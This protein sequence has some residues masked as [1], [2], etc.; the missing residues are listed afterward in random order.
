MSVDTSKLDKETKR[1]YWSEVISNFE[2]SGMR[3]KEYCNQNSLKYDHLAYYLQ[4]HR[5]MQGEGSDTDFIPIELDAVINSQYVVKVDNSIE[6]KLPSS[7]G[8]NQ[9]VAL[10]A[11]LRKS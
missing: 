5:K 1:Q 2:Q 10:I 6:V 8:I 11:A 9:V 4:Q 7:S 3:L